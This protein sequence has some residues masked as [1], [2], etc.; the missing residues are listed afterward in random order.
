MAA[1]RR[2]LDMEQAFLSDC[3]G[4]IAAPAPTAT[5]ATR[6]QAAC[7]DPGP[8]FCACVNLI[9]IALVHTPT[10]YV[11]ATVKTW[12]NPAYWR[13]V[14]SS[15][16]ALAGLAADLAPLWAVMVWGWGAAPLVL[17]YWLENLI[18]GAMT[19]PR[20]MVCSVG[21]SGWPGLFSGAWT[22]TF[23]VVHYGLFCL[24][25][26]SMLMTF[27]A[28]APGSWSSSI[29]VWQEVLI[30][31]RGALDQGLHMDWVFGLLIGAHLLA[32]FDDF[33]LQGRWRETSAAEQMAEPYGRVISLHIGA[34]IIAGALTWLGDPMIGA[35]GLVLAKAGWTLNANMK[36]RN[37][38]QAAS[39]AATVPA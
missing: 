5:L 9:P 16:T 37:V 30:L 7:H 38:P 15:P 21:K 14:A 6:R 28:G 34:F 24:V 29:T 17:L 3:A 10:V 20:M 25:H 4:T 22:C 11:R 35:L 1:R 26:G 39:T 13:A 18:I 27:L 8:N 36:R 33:L 2:V 19:L 12:L 23:F 31:M 32:F